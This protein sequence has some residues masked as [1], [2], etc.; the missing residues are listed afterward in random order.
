MRR[1]YSALLALSMPLILLRLW[2]RGRREPG[3]RRHV[4][5]RLGRYDV[6][7][8]E[9]LVW[10]HAV[11]VG[12]ARAAAPLV[13]ALQGALPGHRILMTCTTAAGRDTLRQVYGDSVQAGFVPYDLPSAVQRFLGHFRP[14]LGVLMETE[15]WPNLIDACAAAGIPLVLANARM[16]EKSA[17]GYARLRRLTRPAFAALTAVCAQSSADAERLR[18]LGAARVQVSGNLKFDAAPNPAQLAAGRAW[19]EALGR[20]VLLLA[21]TREGEEKLLF[22]HLD[23]LSGE[24]LVLVVPRH[25]QRFDEVAG[26]AQSRRTRNAVPAATDRVYL[27]DTMGEMAFYYAAADVAVIG[28]SFLPLGGQNLIES[29]ACGTP[30]IV[31]PHMFNFAEA[32][33]LAVAAGAALQVESPEAALIAAA[34][35]LQ[36]VNRRRAMSEAGWKFCEVHRGAAERQLAVCLEVLKNR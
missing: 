36:D 1:L 25:P 30:V 6:P 27:G 20:P 33:E 34:A 29:L 17:R 31:G 28:G 9:R 12:E 18:A 21:S 16:S 35:L 2:W 10:V 8:A 3:Y 22:Q 7:G 11:S 32:T 19:R 26:L 5:E 4:G 15:V 14:R 23:L 13:R 24:V